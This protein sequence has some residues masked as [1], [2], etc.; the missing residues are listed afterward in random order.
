MLS[1]RAARRS[2][3]YDRERALILKRAD[4]VPV[5]EHCPAYQKSRAVI[6]LQLLKRARNV[7]YDMRQN[8][9]RPPS[10]MMRCASQPVSIV[11]PSLRAA[12][13]NAKVVALGSAKPEP[14]S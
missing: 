13:A 6:A 11:T 1:H 5:P 9:R 14:G 10:V 8:L 12:S 7:S 3:D 2:L 4:A